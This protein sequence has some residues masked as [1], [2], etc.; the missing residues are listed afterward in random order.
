MKILTASILALALVAASGNTLAQ[1][2][3]TLPYEDA[4][5]DSAGFDNGGYDGRFDDGTPG[6]SDGYRD[7]AG[8]Y[9]YARV[10]RVVPAGAAG[11]YPANGGP[12]CRSRDYP[13]G[14]YPDGGGNYPGGYAGDD[15]YGQSRR[16]GPRG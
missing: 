14:Y 15:Y 6:Y 3:Q 13:G 12:A 2:A 1:S 9:D 11:A 7:D 10:I 4:G 16:P 8:H 5:L